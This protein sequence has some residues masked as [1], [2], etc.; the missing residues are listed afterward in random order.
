MFHKTTGSG[1]TIEGHIEASLTSE[2]EQAA[3]NIAA[4]GDLK[5]KDIS[6]FLEA[7]RLA[8]MIASGKLVIELNYS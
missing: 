3:V 5:I 6:E 7:V 4:T 2:D 1:K 8:E